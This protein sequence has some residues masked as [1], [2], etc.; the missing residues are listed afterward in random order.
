[1]SA[2]TRAQ[3]LS[4]RRR[5]AAVHGRRRRKSKSKRSEELLLL[6]VD[7]KAGRGSSA[8]SMSRLAPS[9]LT[10]RRMG[11]GVPL[12]DAAT[13]LAG[14]LVTGRLLFRNR[15]CKGVSEDGL[16]IG[17]SQT[18]GRR[19]MFCPR[20]SKVGVAAPPQQPSLDHHHHRVEHTSTHFAVLQSVFGGHVVVQV[21]GEGMAC[22]TVVDHYA[23]RTMYHLCT[24]T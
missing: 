18:R 7:G 5:S 21:S 3:S 11:Y 6:L 8:S 1:M 17:C 20:L 22:I 16:V 13:Q 2:S 14:V 10:T 23:V 12:V 24:C 19:V 15:F 4:L 9:R